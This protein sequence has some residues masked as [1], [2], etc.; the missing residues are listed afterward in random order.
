MT[1]RKQM[2]SRDIILMNAKIHSAKISKFQSIVKINSAKFADFRTS[3]SQELILRKFL[4]T[5]IYYYVLYFYTSVDL[6]EFVEH[7]A[8]Y[9]AFEDF[10]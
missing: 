1:S 4:I 3:P 10:F 7:Y 2:T 9:A 5:K 8:W 6:S